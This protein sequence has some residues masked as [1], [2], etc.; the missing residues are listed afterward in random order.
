MGYQQALVSCEETG[1]SGSDTDVRC[2]FA[3][4]L[5]GSDAFGR[6]LFRGSYFDLTVRGGKIVRASQTWNT[7]RFSAQMWEPFAGW[8]S[9]SHP[10]DAAVMYGDPSYS[11]AR[12]TDESVRLWKQR[13]REY[14]SEVGS[15][16]SAPADGWLSRVVDG[17][18]LSL[19]VP[20]AAWTQ[21]G[22]TSINKSIMGP[23][24]AEAMVFWSSFPDGEYANPCASLSSQ[25]SGT[26]AADLAHAVST[27]PGTEL[28]AGPSDVTVGG[29]QAQH[30]VLSVREDVGCDPGYFYT[31]PDVRWGALWPGTTVGDTIQLWIVDVDGTTLFIEAETTEQADVDLE[32]EIKQIIGSIRFG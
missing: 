10:D 18:P 16:E 8:L 2:T 29:L 12:L 1:H 20:D 7:E 28:V 24:G 27:A 14:V 4:H 9:R 6:G 26:S 22:Q 17:V 30:V 31:W 25:P 3:F 11:G 13:T 23:Q 21:F 15:I 19:R 5:L 32:R